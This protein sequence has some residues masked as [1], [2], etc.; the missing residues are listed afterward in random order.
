VIGAKG[1]AFPATQ[2]SSATPTPST[3]TRRGHGRPPWGDTGASGQTY[4]VQQ[5]W[6]VKVGRT[7]TCWGSL[8]LSVKGTLTGTFAVIGGLPFPLDTIAAG[9]SNLGGVGKLLI[10]AGFPNHYS[11]DIYLGYNGA[12][13][14]YL[15]IKKAIGTAITL[16]VLADVSNGASLNFTF[17][18][19]AAS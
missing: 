6:Y 12:N 7:V 4:T 11:S 1:I 8:T 17:E 18:Y 3:T 16:A 19:L 15:N 5:G 10:G 9:G 13:Y 14:V 2:V